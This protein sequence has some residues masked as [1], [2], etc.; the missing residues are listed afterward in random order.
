MIISSIDLYIKR[1][2]TRC[3]YC[4]SENINGEHFESD[5]GSA[6]QDVKCL[7]CDKEWT[8]LY[9]LTGVDLQED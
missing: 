4:G 3:L 8:D 1:G 9:T 5:Y 6:W 2:A 7:D